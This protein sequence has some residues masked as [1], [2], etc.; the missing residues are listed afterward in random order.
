[1]S[2]LWNSFLSSWRSHFVMQM[3][4]LTVLTASFTVITAFWNVSENMNR[5]IAEWGDSAQLTVYLKDETLDA[6]ID[7][8]QQHLHGLPGVSKV[9]YTSKAEAFK[10]FLSQVKLYAPALSQDQ[11]FENALPASFEATLTPESNERTGRYDRLASV[12]K[13]I[14]KLAGVEDVSYGQGW[15]ENYSSFVN[16]LSVLGSALMAI[17]ALG[18]L[19]VVANSIRTS[20]MQRREEIE[21][22]ELIGA[23]PQMIR[24]PY[25]FEGA[26]LGLMAALM[27]LLINY[28]LYLGQM[29]LV[30]TNW[31]FMGLAQQ[32]RYMS[33]YKCLVVL[34]AGM[35]VGGLG[36]FFTV[37][38]INSGWAAA[39]RQR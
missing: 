5:L 36:S 19:F 32:L 6:D 12:T 2:G 22:M 33:W 11:G 17:L 38:R 39:E 26:M 34:A 16:G 15:V 23:T 21:I 14:E 10:K 24:R 31:A 18:G 8:V 27:S 4:T 37:Y 35:G 9:T 1:M 29:H 13:D 7:F 28:F 20:V 3:A 25:V 30:Q